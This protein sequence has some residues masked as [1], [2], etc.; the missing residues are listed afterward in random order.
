MNLPKFLVGMVA[1]VLLIAVWSYFD[2]A[3]SGVIAIRMGVTALLLQIGYFLIVFLM[4]L[5]SPKSGLDQKKEVGKGP[6]DGSKRG[7]SLAAS[8]RHANRR[9]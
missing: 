4:V 2:G 6:S 5:I 9:H 3:S 7:D 8:L 1:V